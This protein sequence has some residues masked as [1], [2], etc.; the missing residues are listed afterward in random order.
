MNQDKWEQFRLS[1]L[2]KLDARESSI[3]AM[4]WEMRVNRESLWRYLQPGR[5]KV[6]NAYARFAIT[7]WFCG[8]RP[9]AQYRKRAPRKMT[10]NGIETAIA[11]LGE[12][13]QTAPPP[14]ATKP[15]PNLRV[16]RPDDVEFVDEDQGFA[17]DA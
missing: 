11:N 9:H 17:V 8:F 10:E 3:G 13:G 12:T 2:S 7:A 16:V 1:I 15:D 4:A 6:P 5:K 14:A